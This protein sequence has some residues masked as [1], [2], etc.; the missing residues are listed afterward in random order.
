[1]DT[2]KP[3][4]DP[5]NLSA[6]PARIMVVKKHAGVLG[7]VARDLRAYEK[8]LAEVPVLVIDDE[9]DQA[10]LNTSKP[11]AAEVRKRTAVNRAILRLLAMLPRSQYIGYTATPFA[12]VFVNPDDEADLF[13]RDF[14]VALDRP[15]G[16]MGAEDF[17]DLNGRPTGGQASNEED[18]VR[19]VRGADE[20]P[21]NLLRAIDSFVLAGGLKLY[22]QNSLSPVVPFVHHTMLVHVSQ[23]V[24]EHS[25]IRDLILQMVEQAGYRSPSAV[26]RLRRLWDED[27]RRVST[28]RGPAGGQPQTFEEIVPF[29][30]GVCRQG[31]HRQQERAHRQWSEGVRHT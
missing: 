22:R 19:S 1:M 26:Q 30:R 10:S 25:A 20:D 9:S 16:Y 2:T 5:V 18:F 14:I 24:D 15:A 28:S 17:H 7:K 23:T 13:P 29:C 11:S 21:E 31:V 8:S 4:H 3:F 6:E 12:N 27:F